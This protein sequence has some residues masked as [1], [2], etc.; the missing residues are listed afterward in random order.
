[1]SK[2]IDWTKP[3]RLASLGDH[4][5]INPN[6]AP[7]FL[8]IITLANTEQRAVVVLKGKNGGEVTFNFT[9]DGRN[10]LSDLRLT[11]AAEDQTGY[12]VWY[13][14][15]DGNPKPFGAYS[16]RKTAENLARDLTSNYDDKIKPIGIVETTLPAKMI[17]AAR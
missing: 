4:D 17:E 8:G 10:S 2:T 11:N 14:D 12:V 3:L 15:H 5:G 13:F 9:L 6:V 1:M 7:R 16:T